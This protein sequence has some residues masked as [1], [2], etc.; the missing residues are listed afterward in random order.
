[1]ETLPGDGGPI[2]T[3][4]LDE[5]HQGMHAR[6]WLTDDGGVVREEGS[7]GFTLERTPTREH[8]VADA[9]ALAAVDLWATTSIPVEGRIP[10]P[11]PTRLLTLRVGGASADAV[12]ADPPRQ[13]RAG[14]RL[15]VMREEIPSGP[16]P[17]AG[18]SLASFVAPSPLIEA[19]DAAIVT[20]ARAIVDGAPD[21]AAAA[22]RLV[23]W[24]YSHV[25]QAPSVTVPSARAVLAARRGDCNEEAV[26]LAGLAR[27]AG[28]PAR[29]IAGAL[30]VDG[31]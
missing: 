12:P 17:A 24:V 18:A 7:L 25:E 29:V 20:A 15:R 1:R 8:A 4:R 16:V 26:L 19:D 27:A 9:A 30:Y 31:A 3:I 23:D 28:I 11:R 22:R 5:A 2:D 14:D 6:A 10:A 13:R 21:A